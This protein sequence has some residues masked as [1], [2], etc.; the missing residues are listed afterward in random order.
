MGQLLRLR[1][2][3]SAAM[4]VAIA[5]L[6]LAASGTAVAAT[7]LVS[8][9]SLIK[10][11]SLSGNRLKTHS[12]SGSKIKVGSLG[13][14]PRATHASSADT[15]TSATNATNA[16]DATTA[17]S[18]PIAKLT[19]A[20]ATFS[21]PNDG[22]A[23]TGTASC[24]AGTDVTGGGANIDDPSGGTLVGTFPAGKTGWSAVYTDFAQTATGTV[25]AICAPAASTAP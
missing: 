18:A 13:T 19:Y 7:Q 5:A 2:R 8:G 1:R 20:T 3:P 9:D 10:K 6:V 14:V 16:T 22:T 11:N 21:V 17:G 25:Y 23:A 12:V 15:A 4:V 24:P